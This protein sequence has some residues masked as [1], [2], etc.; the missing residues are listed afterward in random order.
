MKV[1]AA[2]LISALVVAACA[3]VSPTTG[4]APDATALQESPECKAANLRAPGPMPA[5]AIPE[6]VLRK[7][8]SG[9]VAI[10]YDVV[11]GRAQNAQ[12]VASQPPGLYDAIALRHAASY[13][14]PTG[15][16]VRGCLMTV[17]IRF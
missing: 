1:L 6:D 10:R 2:G 13:T 16:T 14:E 7:A 5:S 9:W 8:Q 17:N 11:A 3:N 12:V 4:V 15:R